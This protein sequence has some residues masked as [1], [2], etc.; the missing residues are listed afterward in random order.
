MA[1]DAKETAD[2]VMT[3]GGC[4]HRSRLIVGTIALVVV[5]GGG[6]V[7]YAILDSRAA[8][9]AAGEATSAAA[10]AAT[11]ASEAKS[12][13]T[14]HESTQKVMEAWLKESI[15][16]IGSEQ[17]ELRTLLTDFRTAWDRTN[18]HGG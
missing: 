17:K 1:E 3:R 7:R 14:A 6:A 13:V 11:K 2:A 8:I 16:K 12:A 9:S 5:V 10:T 18:G 4:H 15:D